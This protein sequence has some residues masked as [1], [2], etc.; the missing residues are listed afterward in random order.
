[1]A[2]TS[3]KNKT[4]CQLTLVGV[5][6][7]R[8][9]LGPLQEKVID[10]PGSFGFEEVVREGLVGEQQDVP[11][12]LSEKITTVLV[13]GG[14][15]IGIFGAVISNVDPWF[16]FSP[17][18][19]RW[20]VWSTG[21]AILFVVVAGMLISGTNSFSL[22]ARV[23]TQ[24]LALAVILA[25]GL[26]LP[27]ATI[28]FFGG[29]D[30]L[31]AGQPDKPLAL[32][33]RLIQLAF[34]STAS[35]L[36]V[37]LFFLFDRYQLHTLRERLYSNLFRLDPTVRTVDEI[38]AKYGSQIAEAF[39]AKDQGR[40]RLAPGSRWPVLV[41]AFVIT[42]GWIVALL[43]V[44]AYAPTNGGQVLDVLLP[45]PT[46]LVFGFLGVYFY[47]LRLIAIRYARGD[48]KP[49]AYT[50]IM[51]RIFVVA[52][53]SWVL[54]AIFQGES[55]VK[56]VL[57][58]LFGITPDE[59][60]TW[61][62]EAFRGKIPGSI[63][64]ERTKLPLND[65]EGIDL[66]DLGRLESEGIVNIEGLAHHEL[67]DLIIETRVPVPRLIDW[68]DQAI[69]YLHTTGGTEDAR[70]KLRDFGIRTATD[71]LR[72]WDEVKKRGD[73]D[74]IEG[75]RGLL[76]PDKPPYRLEV[77]RDALLDDEWMS[78]VT[79]WRDEEPPEPMEREAVPSTVDALIRSADAQ[80]ELG[81]YGPALGILERSLQVRDTAGARLQM[82][83][84]YGTSR[85]PGLEDPD[86][87]LENG[88]RALELAPGDYGVIKELIDVYTEAAEYEEAR[89]LCEDALEIVSA[90][91]N[92][93]RR[94]R[95]TKALNEHLMK[96]EGLAADPAPELEPEPGAAR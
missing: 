71:L 93:D 74:E 2:V 55:T 82:A 43:P 41:C 40:G 13:G 25:I 66:Y 21:A 18:A 68:V 22:V 52:V 29:G 51:V 76:G 59:F 95:E 36:P 48:L 83:R 49:K 17:E 88:R 84:I 69:L 34:I 7:E 6:G 63:I 1:M 62:K 86:K 79:S 67:I 35:L 11:R 27:A 91:K 38:D 72:A 58:F 53:L 4:P 24:T 56:L 81:S 33:A 15:W 92:R 90:W 50:H 75:F 65:L 31:L 45:Q 37:L 5:E 46:A 23:T 60:S 14:V 39:G 32:F 94:N 85:V 3:I 44:G 28:Y 8:L 10:K 77:I 26:G 89:R 87:A 9:V 20:V 57:A 42:I 54:D 47:S 73:A 12:G 80:I 30:V 61:L 64:P 78:S 70:G 16:G 19:W 96:I